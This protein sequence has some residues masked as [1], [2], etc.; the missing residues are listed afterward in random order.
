MNLHTT[1]FFSQI[2]SLVELE[3]VIVETAPPY[4][5]HTAPLTYFLWQNFNIYKI[6]VGLWW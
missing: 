1:V 5:E 2:Q 4:F 6:K 3:S